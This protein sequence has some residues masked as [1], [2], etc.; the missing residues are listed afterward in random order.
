MAHRPNKY[1]QPQPNLKALIY[2][3]PML[4]SC[5]N[6]RIDSYNRNQMAH[7]AEN[8]YQLALYRKFSELCFRQRTNQT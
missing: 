1:S 7:K 2:T 3:L 6:G 5:C 8:I 4:P